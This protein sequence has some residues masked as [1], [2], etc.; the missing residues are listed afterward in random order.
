MDQGITIYQEGPPKL[1]NTVE[2]R[3]RIVREIIPSVYTADSPL[4]TVNIQERMLVHHP[5]RPVAL[6]AWSL[7]TD[8][9]QVNMTNSAILQFLE[10]LAM[11]TRLWAQQDFAGIGWQFK[12]MI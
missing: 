11:D 4:E 5:S 2:D 6:W 10:G 1:F 7:S 12:I 8:G 9:W 3:L